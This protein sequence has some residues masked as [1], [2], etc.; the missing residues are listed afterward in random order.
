M[1]TNTRSPGQ[2]VYSTLLCIFLFSEKFASPQL[3]N[4]CCW[5]CERCKHP[6]RWKW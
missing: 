5:V 1:A 4:F 3:Q 6:R 2:V